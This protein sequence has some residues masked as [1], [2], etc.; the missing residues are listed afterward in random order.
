MHPYNSQTDK[1]CEI[2]EYV[3]LVSD[4][5][6]NNFK[7]YCLIYDNRKEQA[8]LFFDLKSELGIVDDF[9]VKKFNILMG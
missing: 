1:A 4:D 9:F 6:L 8:Q 5:Y 7:I 2:F 3:N